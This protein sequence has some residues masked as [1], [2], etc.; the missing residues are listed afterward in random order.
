MKTRKY[1]PIFVLGLVLAGIQQLTQMTGTVYYLTQ[2][3]MTTYYALLIIGLC[4][5]MGYAGQISLGHAGFFAI[6]G[7][8]SAVLTTYD[9]T[10]LLN[11]GNSFI[12][13][14]SASG[15]L[16]SRENLY[17]EALLSVNPWIACITAIIVTVVIAFLIGIPVLKLKGHY[18]AMATLG[19]GII[20]FRVVLA[21]E[22][23]GEADGI[24]DVPGFP[25]FPGIIVN[26]DFSNRVQNYYIACILLII[27]F[28]LLQNLIDSR[29]G[30][31]L[32]AIHGSEEAANA[33]GVNTSRYKLYTFVLSAVFA[34]IAGIFLTH[35]N[36]GIGPSEAGIMKS[37]RYVAIVAIG[38]MA[39]LWGALIM[40]AL[41]NFLSLRGMFGS[42]D[43]AVF[44]AILIIIMLFAPH[45]VLRLP[46]WHFFKKSSSNT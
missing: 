19:F 35:Y 45:G 7:Y 18:L 43:D 30:R 3:T 23:F 21:T 31:A 37:V 9:L 16:V 14:L 34:A 33:M 4:L 22:I 15:L 6:G 10:P 27:G 17:G 38:G 41:L 46:L 24:S 40:A 11:N 5:V 32:R 12:S 8:T 39:N 42:Y 20:I 44:G 28:I 36:G 25:L 1:F 29:V 13:L 26:G 2:M